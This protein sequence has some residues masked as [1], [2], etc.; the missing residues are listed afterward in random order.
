MKRSPYGVILLPTVSAERQRVEERLAIPWLEHLALQSE[1]AVSL[2]LK[3]G[4]D[5]TPSREELMQPE[6]KSVLTNLKTV[7]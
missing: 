4:V 7:N 2:F 1:V 3:R 6:S 5:I